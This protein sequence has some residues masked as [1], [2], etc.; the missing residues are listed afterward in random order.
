MELTPTLSSTC[1]VE[2]VVLLL[3]W[4]KNVKEKN[5]QSGILQDS[6]CCFISSLQGVKMCVW[7]HSP[8]TLLCYVLFKA[9]MSETAATVPSRQDACLLRPGRLQERSMHLHVPPQPHQQ[10]GQSTPRP[11]TTGLFIQTCFLP[12]PLH[13]G[14]A[15]A[16]SIV[17]ITANILLSFFT[18]VLVCIDGIVPSVFCVFCLKSMLDNGIV[19]LSVKLTLKPYHISRFIWSW[20]L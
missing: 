13:F 12:L 15:I 6:I 2:S 14:T 1:L 3:G 7:L 19:L 5:D 4:V 17:I 16:L 20:S 10:R 9:E 8:F 18:F 11:G